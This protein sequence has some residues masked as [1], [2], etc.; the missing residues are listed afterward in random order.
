MNKKGSIHTILFI[1]IFTLLNIHSIGQIMINPIE[2]PKPFVKT[3]MLW[4][5]VIINQGM[6]DVSGKFQ[7]NIEDENH[8]I[9]LSGISNFISF[10]KGTK[11]LNYN[12]V[13]P[14]NYSYNSSSNDFNSWMKVGKY[15]LCYSVLCPIVDGNALNPVAENCL[16]MNIEP[17][18]PP[19]LNVPE[20][21]STLYETRPNFLWTPPAPVNLFSQLRYE[22]KLVEVNKYQSAENAL[23]NNNPIYFENGLTNN[24]KLL[25]SSYKE[26][27]VNKDYAWQV[28]AYDNSYSIKTTP[29][30][31]KV[32]EDSVM[33]IIERSPYLNMREN[34]AEIGIMHQGY[35]KA[36]I[37]NSSKDTSAT[38]FVY[39]DGLFIN[40]ITEVHVS[41]KQGLNYIKQ[42]IKTSKKLDENKVYDLVWVN[43]K[44]QKWVIK[45]KPKYYR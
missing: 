2:A 22:I 39:E 3:D 12:T 10:P 29:Y 42:E 18:S 40:Q 34:N 6:T 35:I 17:L 7:L 24:S 36:V 5:V 38:L 4:N 27:V 28:T 37:N 9:I 25:P 26:L 23:L 8:R 43:S 15:N 31:F 32:I 30:T 41:I 21:K 19:E 1:V 11:V 45:Y 14:I 13:A 33:A 20:D 16:E 44:N